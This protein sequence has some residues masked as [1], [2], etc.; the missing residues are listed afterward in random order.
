V[1]ELDHGAAGMC[2]AVSQML[3]LHYW[4]G[5]SAVDEAFDDYSEYY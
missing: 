4:V 5:S 3:Y 1:Q 2:T